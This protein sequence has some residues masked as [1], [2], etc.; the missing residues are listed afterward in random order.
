MARMAAPIALPLVGV[1][2]GAASRHVVRNEVT[3]RPRVGVITDPKAMF[4]RLPRCHTDNGR[5]I[6]G[7][8]PTP[9]ALIGAAAWRVA[10]IAMEGAFFPPRSGIVRRPRRRCHP[11]RRWAPSRSGSPARAAGGY[12]LACATGPVHGRGA[13]LVHLWQCHGEGAPGSPGIDGSSRTPCRSVACS[14]RHSLDSGRPERG[15][16]VETAAARDSHSVGNTTHSG[17]D[18]VPT[19]SGRCRRLIAR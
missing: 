3:A 2:L 14:S 16:A 9:L 15:V 5:T 1:E 8:G 19:R 17:E 4:A 18:A 13:R 10:R 11:S 6:V 7:I 12:A